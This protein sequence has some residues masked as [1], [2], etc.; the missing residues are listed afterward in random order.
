M[1][2]LP[3]LP[4]YAFTSDWRGLLSVLLL[5]GLPL[6]VGLFT[7]P[8]TSARIKALALIVLAVFKGFIEAW[9]LA[10]DTGLDFAVWPAVMNS[11]I[12]LIV[13]IALH[14]GVWRPTGAAAATQNTLV[15][16]SAPVIRE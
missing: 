3:V 13:A 2:E 7:R 12:T 10:I 11:L 4:T 15:K 8:S 5:I 14:F 9:L 1:D 16:D 6:L